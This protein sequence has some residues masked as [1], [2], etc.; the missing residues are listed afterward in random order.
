MQGALKQWVAESYLTGSKWYNSAGQV[1]K[2]AFS[3]R[4]K[5]ASDEA[6]NELVLNNSSFGTY[7]GQLIQI[8]G[9][10]Q[11]CSIFH[12]IDT[13]IHRKEPTDYLVLQEVLPNLINLINW[14][15]KV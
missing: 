5:D 15:S 1:N 7:L 10:C 9:P 14:S 4:V 3:H 11:K 2:D 8:L 6:A 13:T 12:I